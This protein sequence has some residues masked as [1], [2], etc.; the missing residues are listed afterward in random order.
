[1]ERALR[2]WKTQHPSEATKSQFFAVL[3]AHC[4][5]HVVSGQGASN[6]LVLG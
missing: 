6:D 4:G 1:M 2:G 5:L 3:T